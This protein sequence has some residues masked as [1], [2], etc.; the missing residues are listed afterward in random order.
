MARQN[1][2]CIGCPM[3]CELTVWSEGSDVK[4][5]NASGDSTKDGNVK[6]SNAKGD[7]KVTGELCKIGVTYGIEEA[8]NPT[9]NI[10]TSV[11]V[12]G[13][14]IPMLSVKND[15]PI[16]KGKIM[17]CVRA[18]HKVK[19]VAPVDMGDLVLADAAGTGVGFV[20]TRVIVRENRGALRQS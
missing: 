7:I 8:S 14:D 2:I 15:R 5:G 16:P 12:E 13:G 4:D 19:M 17:D 1:I 10:A 9:R 3:G 11:R 18:V 20:A 6:D